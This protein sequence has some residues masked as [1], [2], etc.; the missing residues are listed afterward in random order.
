VD[1]QTRQVDNVTGL[2]DRTVTGCWRISL[3]VVGRFHL[4]AAPYRGLGLAPAPNR[5]L[6]HVN[7][8]GDGRLALPCP[9]T[10]DRPE[11]LVGRSH[12]L[13]PLPGALRRL[14]L[15]LLLLLLAAVT[16]VEL[17][18][19]LGRAMLR[20][21]GVDALAQAEVKHF[22]VIHVGRLLSRGLSQL[23]QPAATA[24]G[25]ELS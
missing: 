15:L 4:E 10:L 9:Y 24:T 23:S 13:Q 22:G 21:L 12:P 8:P 25:H 18:L 20:L 16:V 3:T 5:R 7:V 6:W 2:C 19:G 1:I 11:L 14:L 17:L